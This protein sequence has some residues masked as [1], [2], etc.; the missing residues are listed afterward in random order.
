MRT[1]ARARS[2]LARLLVTIATIACG[3][4]AGEPRDDYSWIRGANN[5]PSCASYDAQIW[6]D[7]DAGS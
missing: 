6:I 2:A 4:A 5:V 7:Y 1:G 3:A